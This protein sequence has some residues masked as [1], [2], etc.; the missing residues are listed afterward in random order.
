MI[1]AWEVYEKKLPPKNMS[2]VGANLSKSFLL[3]GDYL[4]SLLKK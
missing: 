2:P 3:C 1:P 4:S